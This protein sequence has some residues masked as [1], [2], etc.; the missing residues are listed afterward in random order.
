[1]PSATNAAPLAIRL[2]QLRETGITGRALTQPQVSRVLGVSV[3]LISSW[4][5]GKSVPP[6]RRLEAYAR[7]FAAQRVAQDG[8]VQL[9]AVEQLSE[10]EH[11]A[12]E[13]L[14]TQLMNMR[15]AA[16]HTS[17]A[18]SDEPRSPLQFAA[19]EAITI[20]CSELPQRLRTELSY[21]D[22]DD[23]D[24]VESYRIADLDTLIELLPHVAA[25]NPTSPIKIGLDSELT[26]DD[27][28]AHLIVLG[29]VD[30]NKITRGL[31]QYLEHMPVRQLERATDDD[32]GGFSV[33]TLT[34]LKEVRP[35]LLDG[36]SELK[37]DVAHFLRA[38]N[39]YNHQR[40]LTF[41]HGSYSR[42][43][44]GVVRALTDSKIKKRNATY[45]AERFGNQDAY[46]IVCRVKIVANEIIVPDW[47]LD[48]IRLHEWP[49]AGE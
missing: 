21:A 16:M 41:F 45:I 40:T 6:A 7:L 42:G 12:Y 5:Q 31:L 47:T 8:R 19:G 18:I 25:L 33:R 14:A 20:A 34:G 13:A 10:P 48:E 26:A 39:P 11:K 36:G 15:A 24:Y 22:P 43:S 23:P 38:P 28:S 37:E 4:E 27:R 46:S 44:R 29:G 49:E 3:P 9:P 17:R 30:F 32:P 1:M 35:T 2:R